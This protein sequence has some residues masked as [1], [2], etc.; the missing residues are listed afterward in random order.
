M[1]DNRRLTILGG[2]GFR[3]PLIVNALRNTRGATG[4][5][6]VTLYDTDAVRLGVIRD[7]LTAAD[8]SPL[9]R[10]EIET[11]LRRAL[12]NASVVFLAIRVGGLRARV[13][14]ER[15]AL[16]E[17]VVGQETTGAGG[18]C[19][20]LRTVPVVL[21]LAEAIRRHAPEAWVINFTNPAGMVTE[22]LRP[23][24]GRRVVGICDSPVGLFRR[25]ARALNAEFDDLEFDYAGLNHLGWLRRADRDGHDLLPGL[26]ARADL[27]AALEEG[28]LFGSPLLQRLGTIPNEYLYYYYFPDDAVRAAMAAR[29][30][31]GELLLRQQSAFYSHAG[32]D[33]AQRWERARQQ[34]EETYLAESRAAAGAGERDPADLESGG[35]EQVAIRVMT[36]LLEGPPARL[37]LNVPN[38]GGALPGLDEDAVV[39]VPCDVDGSG[40]RPVAVVALDDAADELVTSVKSTERATI[41]AAT[42]GSRQAAIKAL[43]GHPLVVSEQIAERIIDRQLA[44]LPDLRSVL[45]SP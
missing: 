1:T 15:I 24:L 40:A 20:G 2:G 30:T 16:A 9:P 31:R 45:T 41:D 6:T 44:E 12:R 43:A 18:V 34:R 21:E 13:R 32:P 42:R 39:E 29:E 3:V 27:L 28:R 11:D 23:I 38:V 7:V 26:L 19:Y 14:D 36:A 33:A 25:V 10:V 5:S 8:P 17:G 4:I 35:Y 22:A 37:V